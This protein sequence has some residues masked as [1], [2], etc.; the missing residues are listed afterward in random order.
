M[1]KYEEHACA[2]IAG[3]HVDCW[4]DNAYGDL[5]NG[6]TTA[7]WTPVLVSG[8]SNAIEVSAGGNDSCAV[9]ATGGVDCWGEDYA[10]SSVGGTRNPALLTVSRPTPV[11]GVTNATQVSAG[12]SHDCALRST[13]DIDCW[14]YGGFG[15][16]GAPLYYGDATAT[17]QVAGISNATQI[18]AGGGDTCAVLAT[19]GIDCWGSNYNGVLGTTAV[20]G[21]ASTTNPVSVSG[22]S[23]A[24]QISAGQFDTCATLATGH[25]L[26][27]GFN[28]SGELGDGKTSRNPS[29]LPV[30]VRAISNAKDVTESFLTGCAL[31]RTHRIDCWGPD[32]S[33]NWNHKSLTPAPVGAISNAIQV[34]TG[35]PG[36]CAVLATGAV[37]CVGIGRV[38]SKQLGPVHLV[39]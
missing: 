31:L 1:N 33:G 12:V 20:K 5:G 9:L 22:I 28:A 23:N 17:V 6:T 8:V 34:S 24:T 26:C 14:G 18:S 36:W 38:A 2:L 11:T 39:G 21:S 4:G 10:E 29:Y 35:A 25:I 32:P 13:G 27:W 16:L 7:S 30:A 3:G 37:D 19:G 15:Q